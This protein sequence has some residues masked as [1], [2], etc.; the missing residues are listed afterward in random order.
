MKS[1]LALAAAIALCGS[2]FAAT[3]G[4]HARS[5]V[6]TVKQDARQIGS[7]ARQDFRRS[8]RADKFRQE[9]ATDRGVQHSPA[10]AMGAGNSGVSTD[11]QSR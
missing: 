9:Q 4:Q 1:A 7:S 11:R 6:D 5:V 2:A 8:V 10:Q 3:P